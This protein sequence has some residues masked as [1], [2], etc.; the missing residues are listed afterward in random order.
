M[1]VENLRDDSKVM[2]HTTVNLVS[3]SLRFV[4]LYLDMICE[5]HSFIEQWLRWKRGR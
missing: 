1:M 2:K 3:V 5:L 4:A